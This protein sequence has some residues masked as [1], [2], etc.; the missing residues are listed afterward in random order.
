MEFSYSFL[1]NVVDEMPQLLRIGKRMA[2]RLALP[3]LDQC[4]KQ[5]DALAES[6]TELK[7]QIIISINGQNISQIDSICLSQLTIGSLIN[8]VEKDKVNEFIFAIN[9]ALGDDLEFADQITSGRSINQRVVF[10]NS[11][12][13]D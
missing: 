7:M 12:K 9:S 8:E 13:R 5:T 6:L 4:K 3:L 10:E 1:A 2:F 11:L